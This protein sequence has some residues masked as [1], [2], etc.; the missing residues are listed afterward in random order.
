M[1]ER[2]VAVKMTVRD[3]ET[4]LAALK[5]VGREGEAAGKKIE[6]AGKR[7]VAAAGPAQRS[8]Q[9]LSRVVANFGGPAGAMVGNLGSM[10]GGMSGLG[11]AATALGATM[12]ALTAFLVS[13]AREFAEFE[14][15]QLRIAGVLTATGQA[16]G[17]TK[18]ELVALADAL[19]GST[20]F[21]DKDILDA[22]G[23]LLTFKSVAGDT[24]DRTLKVAVD[25]A[26]VMGTDV[27][28]SVLQLGKALEDPERGLTALTRSGVS[29]SQAQKDQIKA[30]I[31]AGKEAQAFALILKIVEGQVGGAATR[32]AEG[33][34]GSFHQ[35]SKG[36]GDVKKAA[37][38][39]IAD[40]E[41]MTGVL[42]GLGRM[43]QSVADKGAIAERQIK[44]LKD[45]AEALGA[46][47]KFFDRFI[48]GLGLGTLAVKPAEAVARRTAEQIRIE[49]ETEAEIEN[50]NAGEALARQ[51]EAAEARRRERK[52][53]AD[54]KAGEAGAKEREKVLKEI[55]KIEDDAEKK[56]AADKFA[57]I[58]IEARQ[59]LD[60][61]QKLLNEKKISL[62]DFARAETAIEARRI[63]EGEE[64]RRQ[65]NDKL[66]EEARKA[67]EK[68]AEEAARPWEKLGDELGGIFRGL[69][70]DILA[71]GK[72]TGAELAKAFG[73]AFGNLAF[74]LSNQQIFN[75]LL[76]GI[77][78][79]KP[80]AGAQQ[81][82]LFNLGGSLSG[83]S[84]FGQPVF[85]ESAAD[86][87]AR[88]GDPVS[89][90]DSP[91]LLQTGL[92]GAATGFG[93][94]SI[95][96]GLFPGTFTGAGSQ[97][98]GTLGGTIGSIGGSIIGG[99]VGGII[100][101]L[102]GSLLGSIF[103]GLFGNKRPSVGPNAGAQLGLAG[104][105]A[106]VQGAGA[107][108]GGD[109]AAGTSFAGALAEAINRFT[110]ETDT[111][112]RGIGGLAARVFSNRFE[113][114]FG[115]GTLT[116][117]SDAEAVIQNTLFAL[118]KRGDI[119]EGFGARAAT[120]MANSVAT[121]LEGLL[122]DIEFAETLDDIL[123]GLEATK[124]E[125]K[126][127]E[128]QARK[129]AQEQVKAITG[130]VDKA[131]EL[132]FAA[133]AITGRDSLVN[134][135][136]DFTAKPEE[137]TETAKALAA[138]AAN[139]AVLRE[140]ADA[141]GLTEARIAA[142]EAEANAELR[143][144]FDEGIAQQIL[145]LVDPVAAA[146][147]EFDRAA[148][149][150]VEEARQAGADL[151]AVE[152][153][154]ALERARVIEQAAGGSRTELER[155]FQEVAFG[156]LGGASPGQTLEGTRAAFEA[157]SAQALAGDAA[158][159]ARLPELGQAFLDASRGFFASSE[160]FQSDRERVLDV[161]GQ[162]VGAANNPVVAAINDNA[163]EDRRVFLQ[164]L[165][166]LSALR[167]LTVEQAAAIAS[168]E[169]RLARQAA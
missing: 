58:D 169:A 7:T 167:A 25:L 162:F 42:G 55:E 165:E 22:V 142:A 10:A 65:D 4:V 123:G 59:E 102:A 147:K 72:I 43:L 48:P 131:L 36:I 61:F 31:E 118:I 35:L 51:R 122:A 27:K 70:D 19:E 15:R 21:D 107:D 141:L 91:G 151:V 2:S 135:L 85:R 146:L 136:L 53:A 41:K 104:G 13:S 88:T 69:F 159:R 127:V 23:A 28:S 161:V 52:G 155:F 56:S 97:I 47:S 3:Q 139:F 145:Q 137:V 149:S 79:A 60:K 12:A 44:A 62:A 84:L 124:D 26:E 63:A 29:F 46:L 117:G 95:L 156:K 89:A 34:A 90:Q 125:L 100:G 71:D 54:K 37:G 17:K 87:A 143:K 14:R 129:A 157:A 133:E 5:A 138:L 82:P 153:L 6:Q 96:A 1:A 119:F 163:V 49:Q 24:F 57:R 116:S 140:N 9:D 83:L 86:M 75:P 126:A 92:G 67:N 115:A 78:L 109:I 8:M 152:R 77:G 158:A 11:A 33:L 50:F 168:M 154:T 101:N 66:V 108:N 76:A 166:E 112:I 105:R 74:E 93:V 45:Q 64:L 111:S 39:G 99:P 144:G 73:R 164:I 134:Q 68:A 128:V 110:K 114:G 103:G 113:T 16:S 81:S 132:G 106:V 32:A 30:F 18:Q 20:L 150:R 38:E 130:F 160:G 120:A 94:G 40:L 121:N 80:L 148:A 98:G